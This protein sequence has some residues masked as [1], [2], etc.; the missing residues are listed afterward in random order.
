MKVID[1]HAHYPSGR[2]PLRRLVKACE[3]AGVEVICLHSL[4]RLRGM[5][6]ENK[7]VEE[8]FREYPDLIRGFGFVSLGRD[9][10]N[11]VDELYSRGSNVRL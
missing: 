1:F 8:A 6:D 9:D 3:E 10:P 11:V 7:L 2:D 4:G 5:G